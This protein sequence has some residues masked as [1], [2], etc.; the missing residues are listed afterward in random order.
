MTVTRAGVG[1]TGCNPITNA[2]RIAWWRA[3]MDAWLLA[4]R[5]PEAEEVER[6][7]QAE[8]GLEL[9]KALRKRKRFKFRR[10]KPSKTT[11]VVPI[12]RRA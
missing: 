4:Q 8:K 2:Q 10:P 1:A 5:D 9:Q 11:N 6:G 3:R 7:R 12:R